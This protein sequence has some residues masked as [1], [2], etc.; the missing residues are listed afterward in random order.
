MTTT[1]NRA[2]DRDL[3]IAALRAALGT[4]KNMVAHAA[5]REAAADPAYAARLMA[6]AESM[7]DVLAHTAPE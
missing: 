3:H 1:P 7:E 5:G 4:A 6:A 2:D